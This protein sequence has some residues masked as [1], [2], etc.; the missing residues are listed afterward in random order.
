MVNNPIV[1]SAVQARLEADRQLS[2]LSKRYGPKHPLMVSA[3]SDQQQ[4]DKE[5]KAQINIISKGLESS[6]Q[7]ALASEQELQRQISGTQSRLQTVGR[8]EVRLRELER[9]VETSRQLYEL[10][11]T[12]GKEVDE[13][14]KLQESPARLMDA[15]VAPLH[16]IGPPRTKYVIAALFLSGGFI[17]GLIL[18]LDFI[19]STVRTNDDVEG[20][21]RVPMLGFVPLLKSNKN[22]DAL[23]CFGAKDD[24]G[25]S[26][27]IRTIRTSIVLSSLEN[28]FK[29]IVVTSS[30]PDEGKSTI[31]LNI[32]EAMG[33]MEKVLLIDADM[34]KPTIARVLGL[35]SSTVGLSNVIVGK[36]KADACIHKVPGMEV[37]ILLSG[38]IPNNPLEL[39]G[40]ARFGEL[41]EQLK[42]RYDR[43]IIDS[44][45]VHIVS[46]AKIL[47]SHADALIYVIKSDST[48]FNIVSRGIK[49][50]RSINAPITGAVLNQ[51][52]L[53]KSSQYDT[54]YGVYEKGYDYIASSVKS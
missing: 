37:D 48:P 8:K 53:K 17:V 34:R 39:L 6:Y 47:S 11:L 3:V 36:A 52:D 16:P 9:N 54:Y 32:A 46:D 10:F 22:K 35:P 40:S 21:L 5:L 25:F 2:E 28:P 31:A 27:S 29:V 42:D 38:A 1:Q 23:R 26:E 30:V 24:A 15:A 49:T 4:R 43:I 33:Q 45:P 44:A 7:A 41:L 18:L 14:S 13:S 19:R 20:R 51:V 50:L 12:R